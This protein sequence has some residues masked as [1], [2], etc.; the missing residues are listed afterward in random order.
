M[1]RRGPGTIGSS[2]TALLVVA[3]L[4]CGLA[5]EPAAV[6]GPSQGNAPWRELGAVRVCR[7]AEAFAAPSSSPG[8]SCVR[9]TFEASA[10][11]VDAECRSRETCVCG[12]CTVGYCAVASDCEAPR[13]CNFAQHRCDLAC[14][15][16]TDCSEGEQCIGG[17]CRARCLD[18]TDCQF[19]E[20]CEGNTCISD[21]CSADADC[22]AG[23]RCDVQRIPQQV[24]EP[25]AV[26]IGGSTVLYLDL[27]EP[28]APD[29]RA[30]WRAVSTDGIHFTLDPASPVLAGRAPSAVFDDGITLYFED[31]A[32]QGLL[33][34]TSRDGSSFTAPR[35]VLIGIEARSPS[36]VHVDGR[37]LVYY[38]TAGSIALASGAIGEGL[39]PIGTVLTPAT[40]EVGD[41]TPGTAFW[42]PITELASPHALLAG[43]EGARSVHVWFSGF[44]VESSPG[45]EFGME[46]VIPP[47]F[48]IGFAAADPRT[49]DALSPWPYGPVA[50]RVDVFLTHLDELAPSVIEPAGGVF[51]LYFIDGLGGALGRLGVLGSGRSLDRASPSADDGN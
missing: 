30:I 31:P 39:V 48:S 46:Q 45:I 35:T 2:A 18:S 6:P 43:P 3:C 22:L 11:S 16:A 20:V 47:N 15:A 12:R 7:G 5:G 36:A 25:A 21:D 40:V 42:T 1:N 17:V 33:A 8:G 26:A 38:A 32:G 51:R 23:E 19:G 41:G 10:C 49:P 4:G 14:E 44:G 34:A 13:F 9:S 28:A 27:A 24:L 37:A 50:D 29:A